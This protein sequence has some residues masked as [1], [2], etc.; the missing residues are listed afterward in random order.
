[1]ANDKI[2]LIYC[3]GGNRQFA[4]I[5]INEGFKYGS[6]MPF[7]VYFAPYFCDQNWKN[8]N[9]QS[10]LAA[11]AK[12][13]PH[14]ATVLDWERMGQLPEI[15]AWAEEAA[16]HVNVVVIIPKVQNGVNL[17]PHVIGG[18]PVRL[19][20]SI[21]SSYGGTALPYA[22]FIGW[23]VHLLGGSPEKQLRLTKYLNV[24]SV[25][26]N[27]HMGMA[28]KFNKFWLGGKWV[29]LETMAGFISKDA[30]YRAFEI[31]C[32]NMVKAWRGDFKGDLM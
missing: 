21:P 1:M 2:D 17:I 20:Y 12:H 4:E 11:L 23:P 6:M 10:Y 30:P 24:S 13:K 22:D 18:K 31:S 14:M 26:C 9:R 15:L 25:D 28:T 7:T 5:A 27:Y 19:G 29:R 16:M 8:P 3:A 32:K